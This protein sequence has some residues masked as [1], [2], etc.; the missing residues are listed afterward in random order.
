MESLKSGTSRSI[1][2]L[3]WLR[4]TTHHVSYSLF[5][6]FFNNEGNV[7]NRILDNRP[8]NMIPIVLKKL[9]SYLSHCSPP[10]T[11][12]TSHGHHQQHSTVH[13]LREAAGTY[14][15]KWLC[16]CIMGCGRPLYWNIRTGK[17]FLKTSFSRFPCAIEI[18]WHSWNWTIV[19]SVMILT[20]GSAKRFFYLG[21]SMKIR[22]E[23]PQNEQLFFYHFDLSLFSLLNPLNRSQIVS[24]AGWTRFPQTKY[25]AF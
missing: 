3:L 19:L 6:K 22:A 23:E 25:A 11:V 20:C 2:S 16:C 10:Q 15:V 24:C 7:L 8:E 5:L 18:H 21:R 17:T 14:S 12:S 1:V 9:L 13:S 4:T